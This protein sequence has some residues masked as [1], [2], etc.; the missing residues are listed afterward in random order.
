MILRD[1]VARKRL[2]PAERTPKRQQTWTVLAVLVSLTAVHACHHGPS[3]AAEASPA[4]A[5]SAEPKAAQ[6]HEDTFDLVIRPDGAFAAGKQGTLLVEV[7]AKGGYHCNDKYPYKFKVADSPGVQF[8][9]PV[10]SKDAVTL[11]TAKATMKVD[12]TP[13]TKGPKTVGGTF[14]FSL[15][16]AE[17]CLVEKRDLSLDIA[18]D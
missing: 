15:C 13:Q 4:P 11:E 18:V 16:S 6:Y 7:D 3:Q 9:G 8:A 14:S 5:P 2:P 1:E 12:L 17:R 10:F